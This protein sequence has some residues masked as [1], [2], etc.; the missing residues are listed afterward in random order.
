MTIKFHN[1]AD[2]KSKEVIA[3]KEVEKV[4]SYKY[5]GKIIADKLSWV[6]NTN[7]VVSKAQKRLYLLRKRKSFD[8]DKSI[9]IMFYGSFIETILTYAMICWFYGL[10]VKSTLYSW[11]I[12]SVWEKFAYRM[13]LNVLGNTSHI[14]LS[15]FEWLFSGG[16]NR[17]PKRR[18]E[19]ASGSF[20]SNA[21][22]IVNNYLKQR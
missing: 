8:V 21:V 11:G 15:K 2:I 3:G 12:C 10:N 13:P 14:F 7:L 18:T 9:L 5:L 1:S 20:V 19:R 6:G 4:N 17:V 22:L 16:Q